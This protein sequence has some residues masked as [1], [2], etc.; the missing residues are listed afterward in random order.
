M[1]QQLYNKLRNIISDNQGLF[2]PHY[3]EFTYKRLGDMIEQFGPENIE[4]SAEYS[5]ELGMDIIRI[6]DISDENDA[7][8]V[9]E[10]EGAY[11]DLIASETYR[12]K[13]I[14][15]SETFSE[16]GQIDKNDEKE[17]Q[18][19]KAMIND[20]YSKNE[21]LE[22]ELKQIRVD[23]KIKDNVIYQ[24]NNNPNL[25]SRQKANARYYQKHKIERMVARR[26]KKY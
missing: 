16:K 22:T 13:T 15:T 1:T 24:I 12:P 18:T 6:I 21:D 14:P 9:S 25:T 20:L 8:E 3:I 19:M 23:L 4:I 10:S 5:P 2:E 26:L 7:D 17:I 11:S